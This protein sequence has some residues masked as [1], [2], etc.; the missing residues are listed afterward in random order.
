[1]EAPIESRNNVKPDC[2]WLR[3]NDISSSVR[4]SSS[5]MIKQRRE[6]KNML[7]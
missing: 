2:R 7:S 1:M 3:V 4:M 5:F 6:R